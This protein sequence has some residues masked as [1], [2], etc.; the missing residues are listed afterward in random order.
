MIK[1]LLN[2]SIPESL[3]SKNQDPDTQLEDMLDNVL[4]HS[5]VSKF[6]PATRHRTME[7]LMVIHAPDFDIKTVTSGFFVI[8]TYEMTYRKLLKTLCEWQY[9]MDY[10]AEG[11]IVNIKYRGY[12]QLNKSCGRLRLENKKDIRDLVSIDR[13]HSYYSIKVQ[14]DVIFDII[15]T[16][17]RTVDKFYIDS[18]CRPKTKLTNNNFQFSFDFDKS[19][20][21]YLTTSTFYKREIAKLNQIF[22][23]YGTP[24][25]AGCFVFAAI[26]GKPVSIE[27]GKI[28]HVTDSGIIWFHK[29][30]KPN[31]IIKG[32][33]RAESCIVISDEL[34]N[35]VLLEKLSS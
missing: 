30:G 27:S 17:C 24:I 21:T 12:T 29:I 19:T 32:H 2:K 22:D 16:G 4:N 35:N 3:K 7:E 10:V 33:L 5:T 15:F 13:Y 34:V 31:D 11:N 9:L 14:S 6:I 28:T 23:R 26:P 1:K 8:N 25:T 20:P 18:D